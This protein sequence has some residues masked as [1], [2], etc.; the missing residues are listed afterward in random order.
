MSGSSHQIEIMT[1]SGVVEGADSP[2]SSSGASNEPSI[3]EQLAQH[4]LSQQKA[5]EARKARKE[6]RDI[7]RD[8]EYASDREERREARRLRSR[9]RMERSLQATVEERLR[10]QVHAERQVHIEAR[11]ADTLRR[12]FINDL[13]GSVNQAHMGRRVNHGI[14][15]AKAL[16]SKMFPTSNSNTT[17]NNNSSSAESV[18]SNASSIVN[19]ILGPK[20]PQDVRR[21]DPRDVSLVRKVIGIKDIVSDPFGSSPKWNEHYN[22]NSNSYLKNYARD[23][24]LPNN[25]FGKRGN[26]FGDLPKTTGQTLGGNGFDIPVAELVSKGSKGLGMRKGMA[27]LW[28]GLSRI[29]TSASNA[30]KMVM[31]LP[32]PLLA[33]IAGVGLFASGVVA[34][35]ASFLALNVA[36]KMF[37][38]TIDD[39]PSQLTFA[40]TRTEL[41]T[42]SKKFDRADRFG[43]QLAEL[44]NLR[45][46]RNGM[47][48]G[49]VDDLMSPFIPLSIQLET[50]VNQ[51]LEFIAPAVRVI[52]DF[53][54][55]PILSLLETFVNLTSKSLD[56]AGDG[57]NMWLNALEMIGPKWV[58]QAIRKYLASDPTDGKFTEELMRDM[59]ET[60][61]FDNILPKQLKGGVNAKTQFTFEVPSI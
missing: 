11:K 27:S 45:G 34:A 53:S 41:I 25:S 1:S 40:K 9:E 21:A 46:D 14:D 3:K 43:P 60:L 55:A 49:I 24:P 6:A 51:M 18:V 37:A 4:K 47:M 57:F 54:I 10:A 5:A 12:R 33:A 61:Q 28:S 15:L 30:A 35:T 31:K 36:T 16:M 19:Q 8:R 52:V 38:R 48:M 2:S 42:L 20:N 44:E 7:Q 59:F 39:I 50:L 56:L 23:N 29:G 22:S 58:A 13:F 17:N 32:P 26:L